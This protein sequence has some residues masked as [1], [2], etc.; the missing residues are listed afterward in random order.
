MAVQQQ[1]HLRDYL[2]VFQKRR[3]TVISAFVIL[4]TL[5]AVMTF[6]AEPVYR[7]T[8]QIL[9][10]RENPNVVSIQEV[11]AI[12]ATATDFYQTQYEI[13]KSETLARRV[14]DRMNL[15][16][17]PEIA[18]PADAAPNEQELIDRFRKRLQ[19]SP[20]RN[21]RL[22]DVS[23]ES[24]DPKLAADVANAMGDE[25]V[26]YN[27]EV[28]LNATRQAGDW[29][30]K[31]VG[32]MQAKV[33][34]SEQ[35]FERY[36]ESVSSQV[37]AEIASGIP[38]NEMESR[39][40]VV[41]S[42]FIQDLRAK[43]IDLTTQI[44][45]ASKKFGPKH[46]KMIRLRSELR[47]LRT[48]LD[49]EIQRVVG[50]ARIE[51]APQYLFLKR[52]ADTNR[53][54]YEV[55]LKRLKETM[56]TE[57]IPRSQIVIVDPARVPDKPVRPQKA[58]NLLLAVIGGLA[59]GL[60]LAVF[61]EYL[62]NTIKMPEDIERFLG[63]PFLGAVP[64]IKS[65]ASGPADLIVHHS[66]KSPPAEAYRSIRTGI[67]LSTADRQPR[68]V[69][70]TSPGPIEGK[71]TTA[72]NLAAAMAQ[73]GSSVLLIDGDLRKPRIHKLFDLDNAKGLSTT[74]VGESSFDVAVQQT[75]VPLLS[76]LTTGP[77]PPNPAELLGSPRMRDF[78]HMVTRQYDRV[79]I[80]SP[81]SMPVTDAVLLA[82]LCDGVVLVL[83]E[84]H[85]TKDIAVHT[86]RRLSDSKARILGAVLN[87]VDTRSHG[88]YY[89]TYYHE[90]EA[91]GAGGRA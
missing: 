49:R 77:L 43:E 83:K 68:V 45:E 51:E 22:V 87:D 34:E 12:D 2:R 23:F 62:D 21:S 78:T 64:S 56:V 59:L 89:H 30:R 8:V 60:G 70:V 57:N 44:A 84:S 41:N 66:P 67:L 50:A 7:S 54:L 14:M 46:P 18:G 16:R 58:K 31:Q 73:A 24:R 20:I 55:L 61:F 53:E 88:Y 69:L 35:A 32:E 3:W 29:L 79:I 80:D 6:T 33:K 19:V 74:L 25:Y 75:A 63:I 28:K 9:I 81:P 82:T 40:E 47:S 27:L 85:T 11:M 4:V 42:P 48:K 86:A 91:A 10:E 15:W 13:L 72:V 65:S 36:K 52:E 38:R 90:D 39:P 5:V 37:T 17:H 1:N 71:T 76:V 26:N